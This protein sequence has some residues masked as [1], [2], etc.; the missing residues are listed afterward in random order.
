MGRVWAPQ[1]VPQGEETSPLRLD[2]IGLRRCRALNY[3]YA[4][5][6]CQQAVFIDRKSLL[7]DFSDHC[8]VF[9][10]LIPELLIHANEER[11]VGFDVFQRERKFLSD[12]LF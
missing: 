1:P 2:S 8:G 5:Y 9:A 7:T 11:I 6:K 4:L 3:G 12:L 10:D